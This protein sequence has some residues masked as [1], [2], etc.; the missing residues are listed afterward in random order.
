[1]ALKNSMKIDHSETTIDWAPALSVDGIRH[2]FSPTHAERP[3]L[4]LDDIN[5][6]IPKGSFVSLVGP[7]GC[8][9]STLLRVFAG[10]IIPTI[11]RAMLSGEPIEGPNER[12]GMV[13]QE[14]AVFPWLNVQKNVE[15]GLQMRGM[16]GRERAEVAR[17]WIELVG[18]KGFE[19]SYPRELSG[20]MRKRV[21]L[22][23][24]YASNP[25]VL[26]MDEPFGALDALTKLRLQDELLR[27]WEQSRKTVV[28]VTHDLDEAVYLS[29][30][31]VVMAARPGRISSVYHID[32]PR[33]RRF[34]T[35]ATEQFTALAHRLWGEIEKLEASAGGS[36]L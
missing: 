19:K 35:R 15:F 23:R 32:I 4:V 12:K 24:V 13:F 14:D 28:F 5:L 31:V 17:E 11:G 7:S 30:T 3:F 36:S 34:E 8:G 16:G 27:L 33:P 29:D 9:K 1:M 6:S 2:Y 18:L 10:L 26:L 20:G 22:A 25:E 21:D